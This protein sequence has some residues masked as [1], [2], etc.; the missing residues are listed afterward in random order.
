MATPVLDISP[1]TETEKIITADELLAMSGKGRYEL[2]EGRLIEMSP[3]GSEHGL[4][5]NT[6]NYFVTDYVRRKKLG[7]VFAAETGFRLSRKPD[8]VRAPDVAFVS[9][10]RLPKP[11]PKG[12]MDLAPDLVVE[13]VSP[14]DDADDMQL[15]I[16]EWLDAGAK[17]VCYV[18]PSSRQ[19][20][21]YRSL[22]D[23]RVLT[24]VDTL[25]GDNVLPDFSLPIKE[26]FE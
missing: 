9:S 23:V 19:V 16:K 26:I 18:Y 22:R 15:K 17:M 6:I 12:Y 1:T 4:I 14:S 24:D 20:V 5:V 2:T 25:L 21:V 10:A 7:K 13:V 8:T 3:P 11:L